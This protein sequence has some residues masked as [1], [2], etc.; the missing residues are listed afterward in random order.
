M[1]HILLIRPGRFVFEIGI[2]KLRG[3]AHS[4]AVRPGVT[5][6]VARNGRLSV[7]PVHGGWAEFRPFGIGMEGLAE[8]PAE[9]GCDIEV[10]DGVAVGL[11][12]GELTGKTSV[13]SHLAGKLD[14]AEALAYLLLRVFVAD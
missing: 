6:H 14:V 9:R 11:G 13:R 3:F 12:T 1:L 2:E 8:R 7:W 5:N 10:E 4:P